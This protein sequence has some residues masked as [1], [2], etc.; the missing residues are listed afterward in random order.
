MATSNASKRKTEQRNPVLDYSVYV[1]LG[2][3][4]LVVEKTRG[5]LGKTLAVAQSP[6]QA[7]EKTYRD[8]ADRGEKLVRSITRSPYTRAAFNQARTARSQVKAAST[9]VRKAA[10]TTAT[11]AKQ[12]VRKVG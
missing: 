3:G 2:A 4:Q 1:P 12:A 8:L 10:G 11:A 6:R 9:S 5:F 7:A